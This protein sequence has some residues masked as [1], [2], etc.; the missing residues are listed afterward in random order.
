MPTFRFFKNKAKID[1]VVGGNQGAAL[2]AKIKQ[3]GGGSG[4]LSGTSTNEHESPI[5]GFVSNDIL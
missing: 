4:D 3:H 1:E 2:E 5:S